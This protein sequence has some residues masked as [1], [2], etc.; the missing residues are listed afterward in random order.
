MAAF[1][2]SPAQPLTAGFAGR[3]GLAFSAVQGAIVHWNNARKTR[4]ALNKL[5]NRELNDI[6]LTRSDIATM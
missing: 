4:A 6:G 1:D 2:Y 3:I 5:S